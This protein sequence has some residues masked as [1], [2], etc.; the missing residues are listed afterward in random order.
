MRFFIS[1]FFLSSLLLADISPRLMIQAS[2]NVQNIVIHGQN[3]VAGTSVGTLEVY[4][5]SDA[6][7]VKKITFEPI[8]DFTGETIA[9]KIFS[10]DA[11]EGAD[12]YLSVVQAS[13]GARKLVLIEKGIMRELIS[14]KENLFIN[15]AKFIDSNRILIALMSNELILVDTKSAQKRYQVQINPS[16]FSDFALNESKSLVASSC[17]SGEITVSDVSTGKMLYVLSGGNVDNVYKVDFKNQKILCAGQDRRGIIYDTQSKSYERFDGS[18][19]IYAG[20]LSPSANLGAFAFNEQN[21]IVI[22]DVISKAKKHTLKGQKSTL[23]TIVFVNEKEL[24]SGSDDQ[25]IL[26]WRLP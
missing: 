14:E 8:K 16:H 22:F 18:F 25:F 21:D 19:L 15:K 13:S 24:V 3:I 20:A 26:I 9:P 7:L 17:E 2:G 12:T 4:K 10:V 5:I 23:N 11:L 1:L 6:S